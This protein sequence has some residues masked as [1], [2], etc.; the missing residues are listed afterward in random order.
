MEE[1]EV[2]GEFERSAALAVWHED[3]G[4]AVDALQRGSRLIQNQ[5]ASNSTKK[6]FKA[7]FSAKYSETL[8][9]VA[10]SIAGYRGSDAQSSA[11]HVWRKACANLL[12]RPELAN[13]SSGRSGVGYLRHILRFL[14]TIGIDNSHKDVLNDAALCLCDRVAFACRF[15]MRVD[16]QQFLDKCINDCKITG[17]VEGLTITGIE[18]KGISI[19]QSYV[20]ISADTQSAALITSRVVF[21]GEWTTERRAAAEWLHAY[22]SLLNRWQ[23]WQSRAMF[24]VDRAELLR[25]VK[26]RLAEIAI[27]G[28]SK[29]GGAR[30]LPPARR[31]AGVR[32]P[33]PDVQASIP[34]QLDARCNYCS[35]PLGL[36]KQDNHPNQW[37][38]KMKNVLSCCPQCRKPLPRCAICMLPLGALNPFTELMKRG[39]APTSGDGSNL[40]SLANLPFAE[41]F[42]W[43]MRC[44]HGGHA[45]HLVGWFSK[46][47]VCPVSGCDCQCQFDGIN[48][49]RRPSLLAHSSSS[50]IK[51]QASDA[52]EEDT[53]RH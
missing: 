16:L 50:D 1:C 43:C 20:D 32:S 48:K 13:A 5:L 29:H 46:H 7:H 41:W 26:M 12:Q 39:S 31:T 23:M 28:A 49:L 45:H 25:K 47:E 37:L 24:D 22:R 44:K 27:P 15:L 21:P 17:N 53:E 2:G 18:I 51:E 34:A 9:L 52:H 19:L 36:R 6:H 42:T 30:R 14:M 10:L 33:D 4:A 38:S 11:T 40:S 35:A 3:I 8:D